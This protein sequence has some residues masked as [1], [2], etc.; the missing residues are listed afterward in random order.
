MNRIVTMVLKNLWHVPGL[1]FKL[2]NYAKHTDDYPEVEKWRH[3]QHILRL[4]LPDSAEKIADIV[5][6]G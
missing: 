6:E 5:I 3:I 4:A 1:W 2:C